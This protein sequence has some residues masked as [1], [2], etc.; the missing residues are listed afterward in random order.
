[1]SFHPTDDKS[2]SNIAKVERQRNDLLA[3]LQNML[4][5]QW[6]FMDSELEH[7]GA[8]KD[9]PPKAGG[10]TECNFVYMK[11]TNNPNKFWRVFIWIDIKHLELLVRSFQAKSFFPYPLLFVFRDV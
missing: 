2:E 7:P 4:K 6:G 3:K 11:T 5:L 1:M 9:D 10:V 8:S